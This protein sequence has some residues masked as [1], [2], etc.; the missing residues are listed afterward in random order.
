MRVAADQR[1]ARVLPGSGGTVKLHL[2]DITRGQVL[3]TIQDNRRRPI[4]GAFSV[5]GNDVVPFHVGRRQFYLKVIELR[6][7]ATGVDYGV[8]EIT[9]KRPKR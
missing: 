2:G 4:A 3:V 5:G 6:N 7:L 1:S 8:F 9:S